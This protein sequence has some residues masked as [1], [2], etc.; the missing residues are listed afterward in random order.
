[1]QQLDLP[2][3]CV[4][5]RITPREQIPIGTKMWLIMKPET[6]RR[7]GPK[8][9]EDGNVLPLVLQEAW[10]KGARARLRFKCC[11]HPGCTRELKLEGSWQGQHPPRVK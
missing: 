4:E 7:P 1:M 6:L 2:C 9:M 5:T 10:W 11:D 8:L 3:L